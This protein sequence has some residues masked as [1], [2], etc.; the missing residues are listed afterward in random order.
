MRRREFITLVG[1]AAAAWPVATRAQQSPNKIPV[2]GVLWHAGSAEEEGIYPGALRQGLKDYGYVDGQNVVLEERFPAEIPERFYSLATQLVALKVDVLVAINRLDALAAQH[3]TST[4]PIVFVYVSDP[5]GSGLVASLAHP[6]GNI[7]GLS[8]FAADLTAKR[9]EDLKMI[10]PNISHVAL[11]VNPDDKESARRYIDEGQAAAKKL[12]LVLRPVEIRS[13]GELL[14]AF[15][16]MRDEQIDGIVVTQDGLF[17]STRKDIA[18]LALSNRLPVIVYSRETVQVGALASYGPN[19]YE[20]FRRAGYY[21]DKILKSK[22]PGDLP[23]EQPTKFEF[24]VNRKT[25]KVLGI[26]LPQTVLVAA[27]DVIE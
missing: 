19:N 4:I 22:N 1:G 6:G 20:L 10:V 2:V 8:N 16:R 11:F 23:V 27:D 5:V 9:V 7:T 26:T 24:I 12:N 25:A 14:Q 13:S 18:D 15:S 3:A 21:I 17:Y